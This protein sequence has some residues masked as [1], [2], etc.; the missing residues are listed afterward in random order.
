MCLAGVTGD[1]QYSGGGVSYDIGGLFRGNWEKFWRDDLR[2]QDT[3][4]L[5]VTRLGEGLLD[6]KDPPVMSLFIWIAN[7]LASSPHTTKIERGLRREDLFTVVAD[8]FLTETAKY[9]DVFLPSTMQTEHSDLHWGYGHVY[10]SWN[11]KA[12]E[13]P[14]DCLNMAEIFRRLARKMGLEEPALYDSDEDLARSLLDSNDSAMGGITLERLKAEGFVRMN[15]PKPNTALN[16]GFNTPSKKLEF[17]SQLMAEEGLDP[18][19]TYTPPQEAATKDREIV[20]RFPFALVTPASHYFLNSIFANFDV[21]KNREGEPMV[22]INPQ[23]ARLYELS[24]GD[25]VEI[26]NNRGSYAARIRIANIVQPSVLMSPKGHWRGADDRSNNVNATVDERD[27]D[28]GRGAVYHDNRVNI[29]LL[30]K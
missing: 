18:L 21:S 17:Y 7:P 9:A 27:S 8:H 4:T 20:E 10:V 13:P 15:Y 6:L 30:R 28:M 29:R 14:G 19:P 16:I 24:E 3:R 5:V 26:F 1:W 2:P 12:V 22:V 25:L 23:D 11:Q